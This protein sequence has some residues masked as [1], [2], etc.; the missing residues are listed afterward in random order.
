[1]TP[2]ARV[3]TLVLLAGLGVG[4]GAAPTEPPS[5]TPATAAPTLEVTCGDGH[6][7]A[8][9]LLEHAGRAQ[10]E[11][12]P[13][14]AALR[15]WLASP[16]GR[17]APRTGWVRVGA[18]GDRVQF[19][20]R[21]PDEGGLA[22]VGFSA[23]QG[24][25]TLALSGECSPEVALP[26]GVSRADWRLDP[27]FPRPDASDRQIH[28]LLTERACASGEPPKGRVEPPIVVP[29]ERAIVVS[30]RVRSRPGA[31]FCPGNP[32]FA[33]AVDLPEPLGQ[34]LLLDGGVYPPRDVTAPAEP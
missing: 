26:D 34:R 18:T 9:A 17:E 5:H 28:V 11:P 13:A 32:E 30:I 14:A 3:G 29:T 10:D 19:V 23:H 1:M 8:A 24:A 22:V 7:F 20:A 12:D 2:T 15:A 25:W 6:V 16:E 27:G 33:L 4:C 21:R 31:Q